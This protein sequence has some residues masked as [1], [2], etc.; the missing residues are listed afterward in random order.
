M[1][2]GSQKNLINLKNWI[3]L[4]FCGTILS[5]Y[6]ITLYL[7]SLPTDRHCKWIYFLFFP[8]MKCNN[9]PVILKMLTGLGIGFD[10]ASKVQDLNIN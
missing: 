6:N 2:I 8:A 4:I 1:Y 7:V 10:C 3:L 9:D 5:S